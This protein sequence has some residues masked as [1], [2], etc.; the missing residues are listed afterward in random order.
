MFVAHEEALNSIQTEESE[1]V[2]NASCFEFTVSVGFEVRGIAKASQ[3][4]Q[5]TITGNMNAP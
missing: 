2:K 5:N 3:F 4:P 1:I